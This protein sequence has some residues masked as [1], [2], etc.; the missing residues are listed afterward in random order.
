MTSHYTLTLS[1][2]FIHIVCTLTLS[3]FFFFNDT[4][5]T[6]I[7]TLSLHDALPI[8][9]EREQLVGRRRAPHAQHQP[10]LHE[11]LRVVVRVEAQDL[12]DRGPDAVGDAEEVVV[13]GRDVA[14]PLELPL[15]ERAPVLPVRA[16]GHVEH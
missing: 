4:A 11:P 5:T 12:V 15:D 3:L 13:V 14:W 10:P 7:Y 9:I 1:T 8:T 16:A 6:E 2:Y